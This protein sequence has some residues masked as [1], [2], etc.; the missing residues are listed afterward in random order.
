MRQQKS[1]QRHQLCEL[2][3]LCLLAGEGR[4]L[5]LQVRLYQLGQD[6]LDAFPE[7]AHNSAEGRKG[8]RGS[9]LQLLLCLV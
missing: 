1:R 6:V 7:V 9:N 5:Q 8:E 3:D 2:G 4:G